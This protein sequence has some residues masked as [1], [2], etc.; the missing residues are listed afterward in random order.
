MLPYATGGT[1]EGYRNGHT[2]RR[3]MRVVGRYLFVT[4]ENGRVLVVDVADPKHPTPIRELWTSLPARES[5]VTGRFFTTYTEA[6]FPYP[7]PPE[8]K[9]QVI[10]LCQ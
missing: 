8:A 1:T 10:E 6:S 5:F 2:V 9:D 7:A 3:Q 4:Y